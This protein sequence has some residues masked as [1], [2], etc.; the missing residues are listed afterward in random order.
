[1]IDVRMG[2]LWVSPATREDDYAVEVQ[3][4]SHHY[5][6]AWIEWGFHGYHLRTVGT[7]PWR[8]PDVTPEEFFAFAKS[9]IHVISE[10]HRGKSS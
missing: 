2:P 10:K 6:V 3:S 9:A 5:I 1:M 7:R 8:I 4:E